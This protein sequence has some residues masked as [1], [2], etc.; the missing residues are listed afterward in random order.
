MARQQNLPV[1]V[2]LNLGDKFTGVDHFAK[3]KNFTIASL[4]DF[5]AANGFGDPSRTALIWKRVLTSQA[6]LDRGQFKLG[7]NTAKVF[8]SD[9]ASATT[10]TV[11][12]FSTNGQDAL[13]L[14]REYVGGTVKINVN[15]AQSWYYGIFTLT[16]LV[17]VNADTLS[18]NI[19]VQEF[20]SAPKASEGNIPA[21]GET[22]VFIALSPLG[23]GSG[24]GGNVTI[25]NIV[26]GPAKAN[27]F[28]D[29]TINY[30][31]GTTKTIENA[32]KD[33]I[34]GKDGESVTGPQG[35]YY[36]K[37]YRR[38][39]TNI[40]GNSGPT[41]VTWEPGTGAGQLSGTNSDNWSLTVPAGTDTVYE[42][43]A[44]FNPSAST[45]ISSGEW[46]SVFFAGSEGPKGEQGLTGRGITNVEV[47]DA[48]PNGTRTV[49]ITIADAD[50]GNPVTVN[51]GTIDDGQDGDKGDSLNAELT[52]N[53]DLTIRNATTNAI[54]AGPVNVKGPQGDE[55]PVSTTPGPAGPAI[56][57]VTL[58]NPSANTFSFTFSLD[59]T[60]NT[61]YTTDT[62]NVQE[63]IDGSGF[64]STGSGYDVDTDTLTIVGTGTNGNIV[65]TGLKG[66]SG[67]DGNSVAIENID[68][69]HINE[70]FTFDIVTYDGEGN[71]LSR[72]TTPDLRGND[73]AKGDT[74]PQ[75]A[76]GIFT[77]KLYYP[78]NNTYTTAP[79]VGPVNVV[80]DAND[81]AVESATL[82]AN[83]YSDF[84][85][86]FAVATEPKQVY[87]A[88]SSIDYAENTQ[89]EFAIFFSTPY[90]AGSQGPSGS[91][92][93]SAYEI[94]VQDGGFVGTEQ[95]W[96]A[97][98]DGS[99]G[100]DGVQGLSRIE[101]YRPASSSETDQPSGIII[102]T[103]D[104]SFVTSSLNAEWQTAFPGIGSD[105]SFAIINPALFGEDAT[106]T[107][108]DSAWAAS[109]TAG[110]QG[111][112]GPA[113]P[114]GKD[115]G[116]LKV[117]GNQGQIIVK[118]SNDTDFDTAWVSFQSGT[119][120]NIPVHFVSNGGTI[121]ATVDGGDHYIPL[122]PST[123]GGPVTPGAH[124]FTQVTN[125][126]PSSFDTTDGSMIDSG[127][128]AHHTQQ[129]HFEWDSDESAQQYA[130]LAVPTTLLGTLTKPT[131]HLL[132]GILS[133]DDIF[134]ISGT[135]T[136]Y[137][138]F[139]FLLD[140]SITIQ[141]DV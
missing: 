115:G 112:Q 9:F 46:S 41:D 42:V 13:H 69:S 60:A 15:Q 54:I 38:S 37:L 74:G 131:I 127:V 28:H 71:E 5:Q 122:K 68:T 20:A 32:F 81:N 76:Q 85:T 47:G 88:E 26:V 90:L 137:S 141:I 24:S 136:S 8:A 79:T 93:R 30:S 65:I 108:D 89:L 36:V 10:F 58:N 83:W 56:D 2:T 49:T 53:G 95:E 98:L 133:P 96:L 33:G 82:P 86:A 61:S 1:D 40:T 52:A 103:N 121:T 139:Y 3:S 77:T 92:G 35:N 120:G 75:G 132:N 87:I 48:D 57:G 104:F 43:E 59:D 138:G 114:A 6:D 126:Q 129:V 72:T 100:T 135:P 116:G 123:G 51:A 67:S 62:F 50:G 102:N 66:A 34:D 31:D 99:N 119:E 109:F 105:I 125:A 12:R 80:W 63:G 4:L 101:L 14:L 7:D 117:G 94:A 25:T 11:S 78:I 113:G 107:I 73:G 106:Y 97:S 22:D 45:N 39:S 27:L 111:A 128:D 18:F 19:E 23:T 44:F 130:I 84:G 118:A 134:P 64:T 17:E 55:G 140:E 91:D 16:G 29:L 124:L 21:A 110:A 70:H